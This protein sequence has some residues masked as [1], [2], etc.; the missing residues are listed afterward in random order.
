[1]IVGTHNRGIKEYNYAHLPVV[2]IDRN[3]NQDIPVIESD[4]YNGGVL[5]T[6][7]LI[8]RGAKKIIHTNGPI[9]LESPTKRRRLAYEDTM[10][11]YGL[12][13]IT[14]TVDFNIPYIEKKRSLLRFLKITPILMLFL[15]QMMLMLP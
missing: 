12:T 7:H 9:E 13:P 15:L 10:K 6:T 2:A 3:M 8:K 1:M 4:N 14:V 5:A 11:A